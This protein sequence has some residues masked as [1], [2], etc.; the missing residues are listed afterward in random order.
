MKTGNEILK[1]IGIILCLGVLVPG[2][3]K[4]INPPEIK[5][6]NLPKSVQQAEIS[7]SNNRQQWT[8][9]VVKVLGLR[10]QF[11]KDTLST[12]SGDG[13]F[14][15]DMVDTAYFDPPPHDSKYFAD[16]L[17]FQDFYWNKMSVGKIGLESKIFPDRLEGAYQLP[18][19]IWQYNHNHTEAQLDFG[20]A[21]L[22]RD[23]VLEADKD[24]DIEWN[25]Y[26]L[27]VVFHAGAGAE[28]D[29]GY[30]T[31]P[32]DIPSAWLTAE[33]LD[34]LGYSGGILTDDGERIP[35]GLILPEME[36]H[37]GVQISMA[38]VITS[39][40]GHWLGLPALYDNDTDVFGDRGN[41]VVGKWSLMDRGFGNF[42]GSIPGQLDAWSRIYMGWLE[43]VEI[44]PGDYRIAALGF[45]SDTI[46]EVYKI[47]IN[48]TEYF[49]LSCRARDPENDSIAVGIDSK[50]NKM[51]YNDDYTVTRGFGFRDLDAG[52]GVPLEIDNLDFD[53]PGSGILIWHVDESGGKLIIEEGR[54]NSVDEFRGLDLEEAD[55]AQ[56]IGERYP[57]LTAGYGT[58][59]GIYTDAWFR[60][61]KHHQDSNQGFGVG[62]NDYS[63]PSSLDNSGSLT[64]IKIGNFSP[65]STV[66]SFTYL[67]QNI[68]FNKK[69]DLGTNRNFLCGT[70]NFD[71]DESDQEIVVIS[72]SVRFID[73]SGTVI[74]T[75]EIDLTDLTIVSNEPLIRDF[76]SN[77]NSNKLAEVI[78]TSLNNSGSLSFN[79]LISGSVLDYEMRQYEL[80]Q[81][82]ENYGEI[83]M[84]AVG[85]TSIGEVIFTSRICFGIPVET[86]TQLKAYNDQLQP[87][88]ELFIPERIKAFHRLGSYTS[89]IVLIFG[90]SSTVYL[91][92]SGEIELLGTVINLQNNPNSSISSSALADFNSSGSQDLCFLT[93]DPNQIITV[94]DIAE[95]GISSVTAS[96]IEGP[97]TTLY[98]PIPVD[99]D[100]DGQYEIVGYVNSDPTKGI[101]AFEINGMVVDRFP[102]ISP[103][104]TSEY[105]PIMRELAVFDTDNDGFW[106]YFYPGQFRKT[107]IT[108]QGNQAKSS[109]IGRYDQRETYR[110]GFPL[111]VSQETPHFRFCQLDTTEELEMVIWGDGMLS[112]HKYNLFAEPADIWWGQPFRD[113]DHSN[114][115]WEPST[116]FSSTDDKPIIPADKCYNW[117]NPAK[118]LTYFRYFL[119]FDADV[120][121]EVFDILGEK[122]T[123]LSGS[124]TAG[125][126]NEILWNTSNIPRGGYIAILKA[127]S[128]G[129][130][131]KHK[132]KVAVLKK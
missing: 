54:F 70:G 62:F 32:H 131:E 52:Y 31:T 129:R 45:A 113:N 28:F 19:K 126:T 87:E 125:T 81:N 44:E 17:T 77:M 55:G 94:T 105:F 3:G 89:D 71:S 80:M 108:S 93:R 75:S 114:A 20:L 88:N 27:V 9:G 127:S 85:D 130:N 116:P 10:V 90:E 132:I 109:F 64:H 61:N 121:I 101:I 118:G 24:P 14:E 84:I 18:K 123:M 33:D 115:V 46:P 23:A 42:Y 103:E 43:P 26:D 50:Y 65:P 76:F 34:T 78:F 16:H 119:N 124:G 36:T 6:I 5:N 58:D 97:W 86:G 102:L 37:D 47:P 53:A 41:P 60:D 29:L 104:S 69:W 21:E 95:N 98:N 15:Y 22:F 79:I 12:T 92:K 99:V 83:H 51:V 91:W 106:S 1:I 38:G 107:L 57:F 72:D 56:D 68:V 100:K 11:V 122:V 112:A 39:L 111:S 13:T 35:G 30:T 128:L 48:E 4:N 7:N 117:P 49:L 82:W 96:M 40:F 59:Y 67:K 73:G 2:F 74:F 120:T 8:T 110:S 66:M 25:K 63:Y